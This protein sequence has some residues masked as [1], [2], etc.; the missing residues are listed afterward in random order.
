MNLR[1]AAA[2]A[3]MGWYLMIPPVEIATGRYVEEA[4]IAEWGRLAEYGTLAQCQNRW[5]ADIRYYWRGLHEPKLSDQEVQ[6]L[7][8]WLDSKNGLPPGTTSKTDAHMFQG[9]V[10]RRC[11]ASDDPRLKESK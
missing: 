11:I 9:Y 3:L 7:D 2:L 1:H 8:A 4:P 10:S 6:Q 5:Q